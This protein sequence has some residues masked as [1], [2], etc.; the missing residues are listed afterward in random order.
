MG[1]HDYEEDTYVSETQVPT[2]AA[3][4][5]LICADNPRRVALMVTGLGASSYLATQPNTFTF[6]GVATN[7][8]FKL[9]AGVG[10]LQLS[11]KLHGAL[12]TRAWF[13]Y[14]ATA[15]HIITVFEVLEK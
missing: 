8:A 11:R 7:S 10:W 13:A 2:V 1:T 3:T 4:P 15:G 5:V 14:D 6:N 9:N 12:C